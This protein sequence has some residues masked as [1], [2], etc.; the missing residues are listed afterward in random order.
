MGQMRAANVKADT[1]SYVSLVSALGRAGEWERALGVWGA[2]LDEGV[3]PDSSALAALLCTLNDAGE[4]G[5]ALQVFESAIA[6]SWRPA[7]STRVYEAALAACAATKQPRRA[8]AL[9]DAMQAARPPLSPSAGCYRWTVEACVS[10]GEWSAALSLWQRMISTQMQP[11]AETHRAALAAAQ[12]AGMDPS[13]ILET[14]A[15]QGISLFALDDDV[16]EKGSEGAASDSVASES[17]AN[18]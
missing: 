2:M 1:A 10:V 13:V 18:P 6:A 14:A 8:T 16:A 17:A 9:L 5:K 4:G 7:S 3:K 15:R 12:A 11:D